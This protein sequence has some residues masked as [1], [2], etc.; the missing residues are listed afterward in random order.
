MSAEYKAQMRYVPATDNQ[1]D[2]RILEVN[3]TEINEQDIVDSNPVPRTTGSDTSLKNDVQSEI[4]ADT[5]TQ[6]TIK[7]K[8]THGISSPKS[9]KIEY[10]ARTCK[11]DTI[12]VPTVSSPKEEQKESKY[13]YRPNN[14]KSPSAETKPTIK[15]TDNNEKSALTDREQKQDALSSNEKKKTAKASKRRYERSD[16]NMLFGKHGVPFSKPEY[17]SAEQ[18]RTSDEKSNAI[19]EESISLDSSTK[20]VKTPEREVGTTRSLHQESRLK[21]SNGYSRMNTSSPHE[22][23]KSPTS[24]KL[25]VPRTTRSIRHS[26]MYEPSYRTTNL[27]NYFNYNNEPSTPSYPTTTSYTKPV[28][29]LANKPYTPITSHTERPFLQ[30]QDSLKSYGSDRSVSPR[31]TNRRASTPTRETMPPIS[32]QLAI[33]DSVDHRML[34]SSL[35]S[36]NLGSNR[37]GISR[38]QS[39][40]ELS[41]KDSRSCDNLKDLLSKEGNTSRSTSPIPNYAYS[42]LSISSRTIPRSPKNSI[43]S[44][45][46][47]RFSVGTSPDLLHK[48]QSANKL[49]KSQSYAESFQGFDN[50]ASSDR[51]QITP[52]SAHDMISAAR[53]IRVPGLDIKKVQ[54][55][56]KAYDEHFYV[57]TLNTQWNQNNNSNAYSLAAIDSN[58]SLADRSTNSSMEDIVEHNLPQE[59]VSSYSAKTL[60]RIR[61]RQRIQSNKDY[62][63][64]EKRD[65]FMSR[66]TSLHSL[67]DEVYS[68]ATTRSSKYVPATNSPY[69]TLRSKNSSPPVQPYISIYRQSRTTHYKAQD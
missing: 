58:Y 18:N 62:N 4:H 37:S 53:R 26:G 59:P 11:E 1:S 60:D 14:R 45:K 16:T 23:L 10:S 57:E 36:S 40:M 42:P 15:S 32:V 47:C 31:L 35:S 22:H 5:V 66:S 54:N 55:S 48:S 50:D 29:P 41:K 61:G 43:S 44:D 69:Y 38:T 17:L 24:N 2:L 65:L 39:Y 33:T 28:S 27:I 21:R 20:L 6:D 30:K 68:P 63:A 25:E 34:L 12:S 7:N 3:E 9:D 52:T 46:E 67:R 64:L 19:L 56:I 13:Q 8:P 51:N 49:Y